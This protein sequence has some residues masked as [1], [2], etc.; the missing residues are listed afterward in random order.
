M[1]DVCNA[2]AP[3]FV[4]FTNSSRDCP[5]RSITKSC[6]RA[7]TPEACQRVAKLG[8]DWKHEPFRVFQ[9]SSP[10]KLGLDLNV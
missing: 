5:Q 9:S 7:C 2:R 8:L 10:L 6:D 1:L 3:D 4:P